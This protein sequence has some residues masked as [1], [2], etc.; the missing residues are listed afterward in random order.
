MDGVGGGMPAPAGPV[1]DV[2]GVAAWGGREYLA[3]QS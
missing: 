1:L 2:G 3:E